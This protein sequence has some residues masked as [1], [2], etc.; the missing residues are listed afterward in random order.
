MGDP[1]NQE[2]PIN[3]ASLLLKPVLRV[4]CLTV[5]ILSV[6]GAATS[7]DPTTAQGLFIAILFFSCLAAFL[8]VMCRVLRSSGNGK[9]KYQINEKGGGRKTGEVNA[10]Y[11]DEKAAGE[12]K[13]GNGQEVGQEPWMNNYVPYGKNPSGNPIEQVTFTNEQEREG[14]E[15]TENKEELKKNWKENYVPY[16]DN[17]EE[18]GD[19][20]DKKEVEKVP[21]E[22]DDDYE[23]EEERDAD[24]KDSYEKE[25]DGKEKL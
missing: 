7:S 1:G 23:E 5:I 19:N 16:D 9:S 8:V 11:D 18:G 13:S 14:G 12:V 17:K 20:K 25:V 10:G 3:K 15:K 22:E 2:S 24:E 4:L 6:A 21:E